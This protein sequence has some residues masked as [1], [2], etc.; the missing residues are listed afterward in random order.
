MPNGEHVVHPTAAAAP[1]SLLRRVSWGGVFAGMV[2]VLLIQ[3][4]LLLLG[5]AVAGGKAAATQSLRGLGV[6]AGIWWIVSGIIAGFFGAMI[7]SRLASVPNKTDG[8]LNG[9]V[10]WA[11]AQLVGIA[12]GATA[13]GTVVSGGANLAAGSIQASM[14]GHTVGVYGYVQPGEPAGQVQQSMEQNPQQTTEAAKA[15]AMVALWAVVMLVLSGIAAAIGGA[16]G[17]PRTFLV[18]PGTET[19]VGVPR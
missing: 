13:L 3:L 6:G 7:A 16:I 12:L 4:V 11:T 14:Q 8:T 15:T 18:A 1:R 10:S 9:L 5:L 2:A 17:T 19:D